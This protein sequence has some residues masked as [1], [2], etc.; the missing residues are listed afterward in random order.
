M[1]L[2]TKV[3]EITP[4]SKAIQHYKNLGYSFKVGDTITVP[5][6][7]LQEQS[8]INVKCECDYC[9]TKF[10]TKYRCF[11]R[12]ISSVIPKIA[13]KNCRH[14]KYVEVMKEKY[15]IE[16]ISQLDDVKIKKI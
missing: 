2:I 13:C 8:S 16:N 7:H 15:G 4:K 5:V 12:S 3:V 6:E 10:I 14:K 11:R 1:G 9:E